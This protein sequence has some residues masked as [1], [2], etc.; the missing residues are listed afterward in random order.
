MDDTRKVT[1]CDACSQASCWNGIFMCQES[2]HA[3]TVDLT[4]GELKI[5]DLEHSD[6]WKPAKFSVSN[7][8]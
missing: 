5:L 7:A 4:V 3:G 6:Y 1:V 8:G 2:D